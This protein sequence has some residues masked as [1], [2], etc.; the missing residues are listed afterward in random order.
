MIQKEEASVL[1]IEDQEEIQLS[2]KFLLRKLFPVIDVCN[3]PSIGFEKLTQRP[4]DV[5]LLDMNFSRGKTEGEEGLYWLKKLMQSRP[6]TVIV[7]MTAFGDVELAIKSIKDGAFDFI[8]KPWNNTKFC[9]T[10]SEALR[11]SMAKKKLKEEIP[12]SNE[13]VGSSIAWKDVLHKARRVSETDVHVLITGE[14]GSGKEAVANF[15]HRHSQRN[16]SPLIMVDLSSIPASQMEIELF[17]NTRAT[18]KEISS[19]HV[20]FLEKVLEGTLVIHEMGLLSPELQLKLLTVIREKQF[21]PIGSDKDRSF[22]ARIIATGNSNLV[23]MVAKGQFNKELFYKLATIEIA[24]PALRER[25]QDTIEL[26]TYFL[27]NFR[28][29]YQRGDLQ[30]SETAISA[31]AKYR[32]PGNVRELKQAVERAVILASDRELEP[33]DLIVAESGGGTDSEEHLMSLEEVEMS[34]IKKALTK[35][36]GVISHAANELGLTRASLYRRLEK[37]GL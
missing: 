3:L 18:L 36:G 26:A 21:R 10:L 7:L 17:G 9:D 14:S 25:G 1:V 37:Y 5:I 29:K 4:Y 34:M 16:Q 2:A 12:Q 8:L 19:E 13:C 31:I 30:Y 20:G 33:D 6:E 15:I 11:Y 35:H 32:W 27:K 28:E 22:N 23:N 24:I